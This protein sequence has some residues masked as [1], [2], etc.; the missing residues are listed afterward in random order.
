MALLHFEFGN[1]IA[2]QSANTICALI[3][4]DGVTGAR[5]LLRSGE[6]RRTRADDRNGLA[7]KTSGRLGGDPALI[8]SSINDGNLDLLDGDRIRVDSQNAGGL[9]RCRT[10]STRKFREI[11]CRVQALNGVLPVTFPDKRVPLGDQIAQWTSVMTKGD[12][13]IHASARL[14]LQLL[15]RKFFIDL[16]PV[17]KSDIYG[18]TR[19]QFASG[20]E[21]TTWISH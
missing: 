1:A 17:L 6:A 18:T 2:E 19:R 13:A 5:K 4:G 21:K 9:A 16:A 12:T 8:P 10:Q 20:L 7:R 14:R 15:V 11:I 3:D